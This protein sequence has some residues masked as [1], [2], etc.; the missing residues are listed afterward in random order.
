MDELEA[1]EKEGLVTK[2]QAEMSRMRLNKLLETI[3]TNNFPPEVVNKN[4]EE[5]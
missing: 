1:A 4:W 3:K 5:C 2:E